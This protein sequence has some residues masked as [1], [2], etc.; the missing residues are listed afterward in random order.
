MPASRVSTA[1]HRVPLPAIC[2]A[3]RVP[4][5]APDD[6][7]IAARSVDQTAQGVPRACCDS[8]ERAC[9]RRRVLQ[10]RGSSFLR[11]LPDWPGVREPPER[12]DGHHLDA[13]I[14]DVEWC[15]PAAET[16]PVDASQQQACDGASLCAG[17]DVIPHHKR[18]PHTRRKHALG[19][20]LSCLAAAPRLPRSHLIS[21]SPSYACLR[22]R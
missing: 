12:H 3:R 10:G 14:W 21:V 5:L 17:C 11:L 1:S 18:S 4:R 15:S 13:R 2:L 16:D 7:V 9:L 8:P 19:L 20:V 6:V 22:R